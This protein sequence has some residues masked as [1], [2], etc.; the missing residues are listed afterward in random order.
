MSDRWAAALAA[1]VA[2]G[3]WA[4]LGVPLWAGAVLVAA[5]LAARRPALLCLGGA[6]LASAL[7]ARSWA[8]LV[9]PEPG[10]LRG[11]AT[12][13]TDPDDVGGALRVELRLGGRRYEAWARDRPAARLRDRL[14]GDRVEVAGRVRPLREGRRAYL[15]RRHVVAQ[16]TVTAVGSWSPGQAPA[17][18]ANGLRTVLADGASSLPDGTRSLFAGLVLGDDRHQGAETVDDFRAAG[19][20][21]LLAV[22][23]QNVA[24][25]LALAAPLLAWFGL[26]GRLVAGVVVLIVFGLVTRWEPSVLRAEA[27]AAVVLVAS[28]MGRPAS[29]VRVLSLAVAALLLVDPLLVGSVGF[30]LSCGACAGIA[31]LA[32]RLHRR[33]PLPVAVTLAAQAGVAPILVPVFGG[34]P[35][36][37]LPAN[38]LAV[39]AAGPVVLWGLAAGLPAGLVGGPVA[40][41][42]HLPTRVLVGWIG[43]V[44]RWAA[45]LPLGELRLGHVAGLAGL[46]ALGALAPRLRMPVVA[47][48]LV[49]CLVPAVVGAPAADGGELVGGARLWRAGAATVLVVER[50][51]ALPLLGAL[52]RAGVGEV[53]ILVSTGAR[54][55]VPA[56]LAPVLR[57]H[58]P[59]AVV[60]AATAAVGTA[61]G[62][63][64]LRVEVT[65]VRPRLTVAVSRCLQ[66]CAAV[67]R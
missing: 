67:S 51:S 5:A 34:L 14:A 4:S 1:A 55:G 62:V 52:R 37:S 29:T 46:A 15:H 44:A 61:I 53:G 18:L 11:V 7:G 6:L 10:P 19:L 43:G 8:G 60:T 63:G 3:A 50:P 45:A 58:R 22:S 20:T 57:R 65:A 64:R 12:V 25:V 42:A 56:T 27:M 23:G 26:R 47:A 41:V 16:L 30:Q 17:R 35:V 9:A 2:A 39:P 38:L 24:F 13:V 28:T 40:A 32:P 66:V 36:A 49:V 33:L 48:A 21:H 59:A 31:V 54:D